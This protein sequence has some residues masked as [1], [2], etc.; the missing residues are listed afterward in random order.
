MAVG[1]SSDAGVDRGTDLDALKRDRKA[2]TGAPQ[3]SCPRARERR[4]FFRGLAETTAVLSGGRGN[5]GWVGVDQVPSRQLARY[6]ACSSVSVSMARPM[7]ASFKRAISRSRSSG[8][9]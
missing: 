3:P 7:V 8:R 4:L 5:D 9:R 6:P 1:P 2:A